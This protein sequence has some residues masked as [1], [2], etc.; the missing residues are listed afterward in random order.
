MKKVCKIKMT[1]DELL[2]IED[3]Y[4]F[5]AGNPLGMLRTP[6]F[7]TKQRSPSSKKPRSRRDELVPL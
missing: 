4:P 3:K 7:K 2:K 1:W 6:S 5:S